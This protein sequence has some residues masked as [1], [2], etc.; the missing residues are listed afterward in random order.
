[1]SEHTT[2]DRI[3]SKSHFDTHMTRLIGAELTRR[4][5]S[6][7]SL[8]AQGVIKYHSGFKRR[9]S[10]HALSQFEQANLIEHLGIDRERATTTFLAN[11]PLDAYSSSLVQCIVQS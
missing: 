4:G 2:A 7:R 9:L 11:D 3:F 10:Q 1:M 6:A 8:H 5:E